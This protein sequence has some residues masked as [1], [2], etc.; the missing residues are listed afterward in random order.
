MSSLSVAFERYDALFQPLEFSLKEAA[1]HRVRGHI[2]IAE[3]EP[4]ML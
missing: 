1:G 2:V 4:E 3:Q